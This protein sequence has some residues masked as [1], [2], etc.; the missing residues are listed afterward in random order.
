M[1][2]SVGGVSCNFVRGTI[3]T[4]KERVVVFTSPG[5]DGYGRHNVGKSSGEFTLVI[6]K[7][8]TNA[9][10]NTWEQSIAALVG[11]A[12]RITIVTDRGQSNAN[13]AISDMGQPQVRPAVNS[14]L[15]TEVMST[16]V[17]S[18]IVEA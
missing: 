1:A 3:P 17:L 18:C 2:G 11:N 7:Y 15:G 16:I 5:Q 4:L 10:V 13:C 12:A 9:Q 14:Y 8:G 6:E